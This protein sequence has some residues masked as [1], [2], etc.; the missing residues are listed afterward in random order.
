MLSAFQMPERSGVPFAAR[1]AAAFMFAF[2]SE[3]RG[4]PGSGSDS[5]CATAVADVP[6]R[7]IAAES[8]NPR[9]CFIASLPLPSSGRIRRDIVSS[10][11]EHRMADRQ[12]PIGFLGFGEAGFHLAR[13]LR[14]TGAPPLIAFDIKAEHHNATGERIRA[15]AA[16]TGTQLVKTPRALADGTDV[17]LSVVTA[18]SA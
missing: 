10:P 15:R 6:R 16:E 5:H 8:T 12:S 2:P 14:D 18:A 3:V 4:V 9:N 13:G 1:G 11:Q 7:T 17:I